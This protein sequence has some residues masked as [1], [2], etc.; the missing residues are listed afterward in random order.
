MPKKAIRPNQHANKKSTGKQATP[1]VA[2]V[3]KKPEPRPDEVGHKDAGPDHMHHAFGANAVTT[4]RGTAHHRIIALRI[5]IWISAITL[6]GVIVLAV[7][8]P[9]ARVRLVIKTDNVTFFCSSD[10]ASRA[11]SSIPASS[12]QIT[13]F[14]NLDLGDG[15]LKPSPSTMARTQ[16]VVEPSTIGASLAISESYI[17][18]IE[19]LPSSPVSRITVQWTDADPNTIRIEVAPVLSV[20]LKAQRTQRI[21]CDYCRLRG[22]L[23]PLPQEFTFTGQPPQEPNLLTLNGTFSLVSELQTPKE[24]YLP[25]VTVVAPTADVS[26]AKTDPVRPLE[27]RRLEDKHTESSILQG[28]LYFPDIGDKDGDGSLIDKRMLTLDKL[29]K[30]T[31]GIRINGGVEVTG[32]GSAGVLS[33]DRDNRLPSLLTR[34]MQTILFYIGLITVI[35]LLFYTVVTWLTYEKTSDKDG[36]KV[37]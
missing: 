17:R 10:D 37:D 6:G 15:K 25:D 22:S 32:L 8:H 14:R 5:C 11:L 30:F 33:V 2:N 36:E 16:S 34:W 19:F 4:S 3:Q 24:W 20:R 35:L 7:L 9:R 1:G 27:F 31:L 21:R 23:W 12:I 26:A 13:N 18:G 28:R 29:E